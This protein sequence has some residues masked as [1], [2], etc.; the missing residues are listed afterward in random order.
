MQ[1][2]HFFLILALI[3]AACS[4][5]TPPTAP[6][7]AVPRPTTAE[8]ET[9]TAATAVSP[10]R[11]TSANF[12]LGIRIASRITPQQAAFIN[13]NYHFVMTPIL[14]QEVRDAIQ[15][16]QLILYRS[17]QGTWAGFNQFD[18]E[19]INAHE[20]MFAHAGGERIPTRWDSLLMN[21]GDMVAADAADARDHWINYYAVTASEQVYRYGYDGLF[22]DS[23]SHWLNPTAVFDK[24]PD[25]YDAETWY[26][27][28]V[29][30]LAFIKSYLPD[31]NVVFNG[32]HNEHGAEDSLSNTDGGMWETFAFQPQTGKYQGEGRWRTA[33]ELTSRHPDKTIVLIVKEQPAL[34]DDA[35]KRIFAAASYLLVSRPNVIFAMTDQEG[36]DNAIYYYPEYM[37]DLG[38]AQGTY[39]ADEEGLF[40]RAFENGLVL[41]NPSE[42]QTVTAVLDGSYQRVVPI[43]GGAV[44]EDGRWSGSLNYEPISGS[45]ELPPV[46]ALILIN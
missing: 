22:I 34:S 16:P 13:Q 44:A 37:I 19:H 30:S 15:E 39:A 36:D 20:N 1:K 43:G 9:E 31:K 18:W 35:S 41:V 32:L 8:T 28:R 38:A 10:R 11:L 6:E 40:S 2:T 45:I 29:D 26:Q 42:R 21:P 17:I 33:V 7:T 4:Q 12:A 25:D 23:A 46:S 24:M 3:L 14:S 27:N 5:P